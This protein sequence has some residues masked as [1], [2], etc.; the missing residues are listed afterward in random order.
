MVG[1]RHP[2]QRRHQLI[3][4]VLAFLEQF[5]QFHASLPL[6]LKLALYVSQLVDVQTCFLSDL[7]FLLNAPLQNEVVLLEVDDDQ[8]HVLEGRLQ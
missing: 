2:I 4:L 7:Y 6:I 3:S 5:L 8:F 1:G